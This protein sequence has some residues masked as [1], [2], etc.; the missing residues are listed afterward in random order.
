MHNYADCHVDY[1]YCDKKNCELYEVH[2]ATILVSRL[3]SWGFSII[4]LDCILIFHLSENLTF[5]ISEIINIM[6]E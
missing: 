4:L 6:L 5:F 3:A 1:Y 2:I